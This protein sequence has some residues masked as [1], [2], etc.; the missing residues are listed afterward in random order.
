[1]RVAKCIHVH[2][3]RQT[4]P[5]KPQGALSLPNITNMI[6]PPRIFSLYCTFK[7]SETGR[8]GNEVGACTCSYIS[9]SHKY[10]QTKS[11]VLPF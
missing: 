2:V 10:I 11:A 7:S 8:S 5:E 6:K 3:H 1:M 9:T 4:P